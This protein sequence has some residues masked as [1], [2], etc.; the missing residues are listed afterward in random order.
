MECLNKRGKYYSGK[1]NTPLGKGYSA[2]GEK[3]GTKMRGRNG[4][5]YEV[6]KYRGGK[7]WQNVR[8]VSPRENAPE[9]IRDINN[10][11]EELISS[12]DEKHD[13]FGT[14]GSVY[15]INYTDDK[16]R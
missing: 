5:V 2:A 6:V 10:L 3:I 9:L 7:R 14:K 1:E 15:D 11:L 8:N 12:Y 4:N 16:D 13:L